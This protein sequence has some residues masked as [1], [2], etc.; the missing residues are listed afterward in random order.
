[1]PNG[2]GLARILNG[3]ISAVGGV[4]LRCTLGL[5][6]ARYEVFQEPL[7]RALIEFRN[8]VAGL[9]VVV[10]MGATELP[11]IPS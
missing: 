4:P 1:M 3:D 10:S 8:E 6:A 9:E 5:R 7:E 11:R 2:P